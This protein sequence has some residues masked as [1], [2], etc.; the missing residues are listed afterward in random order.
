MALTNWFA[1]WQSDN[2]KKR[3]RALGSL[4]ED[5]LLQLALH[6]NDDKVK[7]KAMSKLNKPQSLLTLVNQ[8]LPPQAQKHIY[9]RFARLLIY[10]DCISDF[11]REQLLL[12]CKNQ[13]ALFTLLQQDDCPASL[14]GL[15][16]YGIQDQQ[17]LLQLLRHQSAKM[18][19]LSI[20]EKIDQPELLL[21]ALPLCKHNGQY[22]RAVKAKLDQHKNATEK[23]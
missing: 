11:Q 6:D 20:I 1:N 13:Q 4:S 23:Q 3:L 2:P 18:L 19:T 9:P 14:S 15:A 5:K 8:P 22:Y 7:L 16:L 12:D 17:L 10:S 21:K